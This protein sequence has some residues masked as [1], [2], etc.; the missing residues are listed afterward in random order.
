MRVE[1]PDNRPEDETK[2]TSTKEMEEVQIDDN[3]PSKKTQIGTKLNL[4][5]KE[6]L[7]CFLKA[8]KD[9]FAWTPVDMPRIPTSLAVHRLSTNPLKKPVAQKRHLFEGERLMC[10]DY[11]NLNDACPKDYHPLPSVD[12]LV[13]AASRN[14]RFSF[15]DAYSRY[16]QVHMVPKDE[17]EVELAKCVFNVESGKF[18][19]F[20]VSR[21][22]IE[23]NPKRIKA[24]NEMKP[25]K[26]VKEVQRL[27]GKVYLSLP[28]LLT[29]VEKGEILYLYLGIFDTTENAN[30]KPSYGPFTSIGHLATKDRRKRLGAGVVLTG[31]EGF[32]SEHTLKFNF[33]AT[34]NIAK[35]EALLLRLCLAAKLKVKSLQVYI[36]SQLVVNQLT[37]VPRTENEHADS[38]SKLASNRFGGRSV[39]V[40]VLDKRSFQRLK[41]YS[42]P[43]LHC[44]TPYE[45]EFTLREVHEGVCGSH[46]GARTLAHKV[47]RQRYGIPNQ[48]IANNNPQFN[49]TS[50][51]DFCSNYG[52]KLVFTS[53]YHL[54]TNRMVESV[55]KIIFER[56]KPKLDQFKAKWV[57]ELNSVLWAYQTTSRTATGEMPYHLTFGIEAVIP[58]EIGVLSLRVS[59]FDPVQ[60]EQLLK[61]TSIS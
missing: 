51:K 19:G 10:I 14:E 28:P 30:S 39:Y 18:L 38:F 50:F 44:L 17:H 52:I 22:G 49:Y 24:I 26:L 1:L 47:F 21:R 36:D 3:D 41:V 4:K 43:L 57:D 37:K 46:L 56:I 32:Q 29:K 60:N 55:N 42:L 61:E 13:E 27:T 31:P 40:E 16:H 2:A 15:L 9:V 54:E 33:E 59:H 23:V 48:I 8:N 25:P 6:E 58:V 7:I 35:Y 34:N 5:E 12:K 53:V 20:M 11:T 45:V